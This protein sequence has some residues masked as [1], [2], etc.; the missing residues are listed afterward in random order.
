MKRIFALI[1]ICLIIFVVLH[2]QRIFLRDPLATVT[3]DDAKVGGVQ[4]MINYTN[5]ILL[6]DG[7]KPQHRLYL[8]QNWNKVADGTNCPAA[9]HPVSWLHDRRGSGHR[10]E[11]GTRIPRPPLAV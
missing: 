4:V 8:V 11:A 10:N 6:Q 7:S 1:L 3:R 2:R 5:D 9:M